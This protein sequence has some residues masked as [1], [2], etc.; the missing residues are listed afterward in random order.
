MWQK[1]KDQLPAVILTLLLIGG[2]AYWLHTQTVAQL[3]AQ[4]STELAA[5]RDLT[6]AELQ[7]A[8]AETRAQLD[9]VNTLLRDALESR[10]SSLFMT[11]EELA[12]VEAQ[13]IDQLADAIAQQIRPHAP[14]PQTPEDAA[15]QETAQISQVSSRLAERIQPLLAE[16]ASDQNVTRETLERVSAE[17]SDQLSVVLTSELSRNQTLN[18]NLT[19]SQA[20][21]RDSMGLSQELAAL[22]LS[23]FED[24]GILTRILS[25]PAGVIKDV[26]QGSIINSAERRQKEEELMARM[27]ELQDRLSALE[28]EAPIGE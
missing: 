2:V 13:R 19:T 24:K 5:L 11:D 15:R 7:A 10:S 3:A 17:I 23:S 14:A 8:A 21:A 28:A 16:I 22:Y 1:L 6:N 26:S 9:A 27:A 25:L 4:Q 20:I 12:T 18:N